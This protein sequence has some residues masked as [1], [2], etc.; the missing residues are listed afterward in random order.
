MVKEYIVGIEKWRIRHLLATLVATYF[1]GKPLPSKGA[2]NFATC[3]SIGG[4]IIII[5]HPYT[6]T[7]CQLLVGLKSEKLREALYSPISTFKKLRVSCVKVEFHIKSGRTHNEI[8]Q[9]HNYPRPRHRD[10]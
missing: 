9:I 5:Y 4:K 6:P 7:P 3:Q 10:A 1:R 2:R 8:F